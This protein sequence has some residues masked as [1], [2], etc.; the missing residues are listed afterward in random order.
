MVCK[1]RGKTGLVSAEKSEGKAEAPPKAGETEFLSDQE[2]ERCFDAAV[3]ILAGLRASYSRAQAYVVVE[4]LRRFFDRDM[5][6]LEMSEVLEKRI[7]EAA[8]KLFDESDAFIDELN[9]A[10]REAR[11]GRHERETSNENAMYG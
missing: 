1:A 7:E 11:A 3:G 10:W 6:D 4:I 8:K 5:H 9:L 2:V